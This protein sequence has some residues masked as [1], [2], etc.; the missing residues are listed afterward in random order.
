MS[1]RKTTS[2]SELWL[3]PII[4]TL[5]TVIGSVTVAFIN[6]QQAETKVRQ[7][8]QPTISA[9]ETVVARPTATPFTQT[10]TNLCNY[11]GFEINEPSGGYILENGQARISGTVTEL[12][13]Y[14]GSI[15]L[16]T[17][18]DSAPVSYW[19]Q[20]SVAV[21]PSTK[22]WNGVIYSPYDVTVAVVILGDDG[23]ILFDYFR[24]VADTGSSQEAQ[25]PGLTQLTKDVQTCK[26]ITVRK[27]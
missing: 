25:Y 22:K 5:I 11:Y 13:P 19:P 1:T 18:G 16:M 20:S 17:I 9:L 23:Q 26:T 4:V 24:K 7:E 14:G 10:Q 21:D 8:L 3:V 6:I 27:P 2:K 15:R 12:P